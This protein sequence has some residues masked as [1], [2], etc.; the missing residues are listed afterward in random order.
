M[1]AKVLA[2]S[3]KGPGALLQKMAGTF[4]YQKHGLY[5]L[6]IRVREMAAMFIPNNL[7]QT[8]S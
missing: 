7:I 5:R 6:P 3:S 1:G 8:N 2:R 4:R